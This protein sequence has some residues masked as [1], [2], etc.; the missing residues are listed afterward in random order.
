M[1][2]FNMTVWKLRLA[3][4][5][6]WEGGDHK[7]ERELHIWKNE[8]QSFSEPAT[9]CYE[10]CLAL[11]Y[12]WILS[13]YSAYFRR[14]RTEDKSIFFT[15]TSNSCLDFTSTKTLP[16]TWAIARIVILGVTERVFIWF[17]SHHTWLGKEQT[18]N[19]MFA[20]NWNKNN[21]NFP[22]LAWFSRQVGEY[23]EKFFLLAQ[24]SELETR[25]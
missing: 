2:F 17:F 10:N 12:M 21:K 15:S 7:V 4:I 3:L 20:G 18:I 16:A 1:Q 8:Q 5:S 22:P 11:T 19:K 6:A 24:K 9:R 23:N 13:V 25:S 14:L